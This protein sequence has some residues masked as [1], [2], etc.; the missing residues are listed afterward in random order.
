MTDA[1]K[2]LNSFAQSAILGQVALD[3]G[4]GNRSKTVQLKSTYTTP[5]LAA[6]TPV[7]F[8]T[9][10]GVLPQVDVAVPGTDAI[11][12]I[13]LYDQKINSFG[14]GDIFQVTNEGSVIYMKASTSLSRGA[15]VGLTADYKLKAANNLNFIG[16]ILDNAVAE[17]L[18]RVQIQV[19]VSKAYAI[20]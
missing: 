8:D 12:G 1:R 17:Q 18:V 20:S 3:S 9:G 2:E 4:A 5:L 13:I 19:P 14:A 7:K 10:A 6:G 11:Y 15:A 16:L